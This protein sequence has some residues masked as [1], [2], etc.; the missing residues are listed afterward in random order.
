MVL[1]SLFNVFF[2][3]ASGQPTLQAEI[4]FVLELIM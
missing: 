2:S 1:V 3:A 4:K